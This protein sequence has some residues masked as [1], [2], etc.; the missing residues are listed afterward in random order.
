MGN[1]R[2]G[3][4]KED[5]GE[6]IE[7]RGVYVRKQK[8]SQRIPSHNC[9]LD[10]SGPMYVHFHVRVI[11]RRPCARTAAVR[12]VLKI[13]RGVSVRTHQI[14]RCTYHCRLVS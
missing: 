2:I 7:G 11:Q 13:G 12:H 6:E 14:N 8:I 10:M 9:V 4:G 5:W 3:I 1:E